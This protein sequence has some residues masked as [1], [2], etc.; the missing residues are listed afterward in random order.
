[1][2]VRA[3]PWAVGC[4]VLCGAIAVVPFASVEAVGLSPRPQAVTVE[5]IVARNLAAKGGV[6]KLRA[7]TSVK[8]AGRVKGP[9]GEMP[10]TSWAMRPN[11]MRRSKSPTGR[12]VLGFDGMTVWN[13]NPLVSPKAREITGPQAT[14]PVS[15]PV[16]STRRFS[17]TRPGARPSID[18]HG[19]RAGR[20]H[21]PAQADLEEWH[22]PGDLINAETCSNH[23]RPCRSNRR[24]EGHRDAG[25]LGL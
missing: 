10:T 21:A 23:A 7:V 3:L 22:D 16:T 12:F 25:V 14:R 9:A 13:I 1:M 15:M 4:G 19:G 5:D 2:S 17:I 24:S 20:P 18:R 8:M 11:K 6:E